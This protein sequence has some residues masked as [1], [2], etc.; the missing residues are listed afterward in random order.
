MSSADVATPARR[1]RAAWG[2]VI[3]AAAV[4]WPMVRHPT[5]VLVGP[6][7]DGRND[8]TA[9]FLG[10]RTFPREAIEHGDWPL[11]NP[12]MLAGQPWIGNPQSGALYPPY[13]L[14]AL[15]GHAAALSWLL[16]AHQLWAGLGTYVFC[17]RLGCR[18]SAALIGGTIA[19]G[20]PYAIAQLGEGHVNQVCLAAW[21][22]WAFWAFEGWRAGLRSRWL[23]P[24]ILALAVFCGHVQEAFY[25][26]V[27]L[28]LC[29]LGEMLGDG[30]QGRVSRAAR[31]GFGWIGVGIATLGLTAAEVWP[32]VV[33]AKQSVRGRSFQAIEAGQISAGW[34]HV[35]Q[36][37]EPFALGG[38]DAYQGSGQFFWETLCHFGV[39]PLLLALWGAIAGLKRP[40][41]LRCLLLAIFTLLFAVGPRTPVYT[42]CHEWIPG[43]ALFRSPTR[44]LFLGSI[45]IATLAAIGVDELQSGRWKWPARGG[46][47]VLTLAGIV[48]AGLTMTV[49]KVA[50]P[51]LGFQ[52]AMLQPNVWGWI[53]GGSVAALLL[54][55]ARPH[56]STA[57]CA[58]LWIMIAAQLVTCASGI[59]RT[60]PSAQLRRESP[61]AEF[62]A[63]EAGADRILAQHE[64]LTDDEANRFRLAKLE[65][66]EPVPLVRA[67]DLFDALTSGEDTP[68]KMLGFSPIEQAD[69]NQPMLDLAG[70]RWT[71][72]TRDAGDLPGWTKVL[73]GTMAPAVTLRGRT[74]RPLPYVVYRN[75]AALPRAFVIGRTLPLNRTA[76]LRQQIEG[77]DPRESL[78]VEK[79]VL[80]DGP[81][82][83]FAPAQIVEYTTDRV[84]L[85]ATLEAPGYLVLTDL[86][87]PGWKAVDAGGRELEILL[88][89]GAFRAI[90]LPQG[91]HRIT[92]R[93]SPP[94]WTLSALV[95]ALAAGVLVVI[96][97]S[98]RTPS[99]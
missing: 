90:A 31:L 77:W 87:Y 68:N 15:S 29:C 10:I 84:V 65:G 74:P 98:Q 94:L 48:L 92:L 22:P 30:L 37:F 32:I 23:L 18:P 25:I 6:Q 78:L 47:G 60:I 8:L 39:M 70:V 33:Q 55:T 44:I 69:W 2:L 93:F 27:A 12:W 49:W 61:L 11:W 63:Q 46:W 35:W 57:G 51:A 89:N 41:A 45:L 19:L 9:Q 34:D 13:W 96:A 50:E 43:V 99:T 28:S 64:H 95:S 24:F 59:L 81:R 40:G 14:T 26:V 66:Y 80:P 54:L 67:A 38:P 75:D 71:V 1:S 97:V 58:L 72:T 56:W 82:A 17:R 79:D 20:A 86:W 52:A 42:L 4:F 21:I 85:E 91:A 62:L 5:D 36:L 76:P 88:A 83:E 3:V 7:N 73:E 16:I 53:A